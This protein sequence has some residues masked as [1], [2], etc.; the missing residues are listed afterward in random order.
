MR[1]LSAWRR[2]WANTRTSSRWAYTGAGD[3]TSGPHSFEAALFAH[4]AGRGLQPQEP[5]HCA[6]GL[7]GT[8]SRACCNERACTIV[9]SRKRAN[10]FVEPEAAP[11]VVAHVIRT[12]QD[13]CTNCQFWGEEG[14]PMGFYLEHMKHASEMIKAAPQTK[15]G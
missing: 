10:E 14:K 9:H 12:F 6:R 8:R 1:V 7:A 3:G 11:A 2:S 15:V 5:G 4:K 13:A